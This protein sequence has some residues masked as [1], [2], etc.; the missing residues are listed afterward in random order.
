M[1]RVPELRNLSEDHHH[2]L[3]LAR[4][5][6]K[7]AAGEEGFSTSDVWAEVEASFKAELEP[8][9]RIEE[10]LI[11]TVLEAH[12]ESRLA[13]RLFD[14]HEA[15]REFFIPGG[16]RTPDDLGCFGKLLEKHIRF[17]E[18]ELF[19]VAQN[20]LNRD[21]LSAVAKACHARHGGK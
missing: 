9:F 1:K 6:R 3:A 17:E 21:E 15:L 2:G 12:G 19:E 20:T 10:S 5:A 13:K 4:K 11:G 7:A 16:D 18:R 8:H 14:E